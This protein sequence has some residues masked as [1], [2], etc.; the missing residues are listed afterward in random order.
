MAR[1]KNAPASPRYSDGLPPQLQDKVLRIAARTGDRFGT[2]PFT[3]NI[4][5]SAD[6]APVRWLQ[7]E[8]N[9]D[10]GLW[11]V[12][13]Y[14]ISSGLY[15]D[16]HGDLTTRP[17][18]TRKAHLVE[19]CLFDALYACAAWELEDSSGKIPAD[20]K[21]GYV[22]AVHFRKFGRD[23]GQIFDLRTGLPV[24]VAEARIL[25]DDAVVDPADT[26]RLSESRGNLMPVK[27]QSRSS[28]DAGD[29]L[30]RSVAVPVSKALA[31]QNT[32]RVLDTLRA[33]KALETLG[34]KFDKEARGVSL[35]FSYLSD[36]LA[37]SGNTKVSGP[38]KI[39][40]GSTLLTAA[41]VAGAIATSGGM[42]LALAFASVF[43]G[44][45]TVFTHG[46]LLDEENKS[47]LMVWGN[48]F[49][50]PRRA[51]RRDIS[52]LRKMASLCPDDTTREA[53]LDLAK[54]TEI[55]YYGLVARHAFKK[56]AQGRWFSSQR[57][58]NN[59][60]VQFVRIAESNGVPDSEVA[61]LVT[62]LQDDP[63]GDSFEWGL[64]RFV[65]N[66]A[67]KFQREMRASVQEKTKALTGP[68]IK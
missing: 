49:K 3:F 57:S 27:A 37:G 40:V 50:M 32:S 5:G 41:M 65:S 14:N 36:F 22:Q 18:L 24:P 16:D 1:A 53:C 11:N 62:A 47:P 64:R 23:E 13:L 10:T 55:A 19:V 60:I 54:R 4:D 12:T 26:L 58:V 35:R 9:G 7:A 66:A 52:R 6:A 20:E 29:I 61:R 39:A 17:G 45:F 28:V 30:P 68:R 38:E 48:A 33:Q 2:A 43:P 59:H 25:D 51:V 56:A 46:F 21:S 34:G 15:R 42:S 31:V 67:E 8:R 44:L 63:K